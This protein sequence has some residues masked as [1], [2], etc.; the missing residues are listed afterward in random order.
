MVITSYSATGRLRDLA[1]RSRFW[2]RQFR[3]IVFLPGFH[4]FKTLSWKVRPPYDRHFCRGENTN[5][6][7]MSIRSIVDA[8]LLFYNN[9][10]KP[11]NPFL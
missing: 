6:W 1:L 4:N 11:A 3:E 8:I 7:L 2:Y 10:S 5:V 9:Q